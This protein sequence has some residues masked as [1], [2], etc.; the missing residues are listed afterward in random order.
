MKKINKYNIIAKRVKG[1][2]YIIYDMIATKLNKKTFQKLQ[3]LNPALLGD[4]YFIDYKDTDFSW[5]GKITKYLTLS[6]ITS[7][8]M[9]DCDFYGS[10]TK[11]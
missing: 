9:F 4:Y 1:Q 3:A 11:Y 6:K 5:W 10:I 8:W 7:G 2:E